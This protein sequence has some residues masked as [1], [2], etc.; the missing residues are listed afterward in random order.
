VNSWSVPNTS[1]LGCS[2]INQNQ[3]FHLFYEIGQKTPHFWLFS[4]VARYIEGARVPS[5]RYIEVSFTLNSMGICW[6][7]EPPTLQ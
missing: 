1:S 3:F 4:T 5:Q 6:G 2:V 7:K